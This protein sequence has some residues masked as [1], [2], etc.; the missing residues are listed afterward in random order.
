MVS[1]SKLSKFSIEELQTFREKVLQAETKEELLAVIDKTIQK[2]EYELTESMN[3]RFPVDW[4]NI[5][6]GYIDILHANGITNLAQ[7]RN[8][9]EEDLWHLEG[10]TQGGYRQISWARDFFDMTP[11]EKIKPSKRDNMTV[12]KVIVKHANECSKKHPNI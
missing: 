6:S 3:A 2:K 9:K 12:A 7:L 1:K 5:D 11:I 10:M 4:F 8:I